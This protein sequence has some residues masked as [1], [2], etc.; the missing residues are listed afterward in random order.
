MSA[1]NAIRAIIDIY[2]DT[3]GAAAFPGGV[4]PPGLFLDEAP[5]TKDTPP[6]LM[7]PPYVII[8]DGGEAPIADDTREPWAIGGS[9]T[10]W[11]GPFILRAYYISLG[12]AAHCM[13]AILWNGQAPAN[14]A[15][16]A[17]CTLDMESP[18]QSFPFNC[19][20]GRRHSKYAGFDINNERVHMVQQE[21]T[22]RIYQ[23][24]T[25]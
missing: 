3:L 24:G 18:L 15:G 14:K 8:I 10:A 12:D 17:F 4:K 25:I 13:N 22:R 1:P 23:N 6:V 9:S 11:E 19:I 16:L 7:R 2:T 20:P 5:K 21:F